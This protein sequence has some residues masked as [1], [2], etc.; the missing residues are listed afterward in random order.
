VKKAAY[1]SLTFI[2]VLILATPQPIQATQMQY[3]LFNIGLNLG[4]ASTLIELGGITQQNTPILRD[5]ILKAMGFIMDANPQLW[6]P[7]LKLNLLEINRDLEQFWTYTANWN[8]Q[9]RAQYITSVY[10]K[11][12]QK[13]SHIFNSQQGLYMSSNCDSHF[14]DVG[15]YLGQAYMAA[16][17]GNESYRSSAHSSLVNTVNNGINV[18]QNLGCGFGTLSNWNA[19]TFS[20]PFTT[21]VYQNAVNQINGIALNANG[22]SGSLYFPSE[23]DEI[24]DD[25]GPGPDPD[26]GPGP[27]P[28]PNPGPDPNPQS[29]AGTWIFETNSRLVVNRSGNIYRGNIYN[30]S[31]E[32]K[33]LGYTEGM[34][35]CEYT[36]GPNGVYT[37]KINIRTSDGQF[38]WKNSRVTVRG[39]TATFE[40]LFDG[41]RVSYTAR[42]AR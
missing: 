1:L 23:P 27:D 29:F 30:L 24:P 36:A 32:L 20:P 2:L 31:S 40:D 35:Y 34:P 11:I 26:P 18:S 8:L 42:R 38:V 15:Y 10:N 25:P 3:E 14:L 17:L 7:F 21:A 39:D 33:Y 16:F 13:I 22:M 12:R 9:Q 19:F 5:Y 37:G 41:G 4:Y 28:D 6:G